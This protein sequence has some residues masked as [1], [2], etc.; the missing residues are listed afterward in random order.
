MDG[1]DVGNT[2]SWSLSWLFNSESSVFVLNAK[3]L[4]DTWIVMGIIFCVCII[5]L[6]IMHRSNSIARHALI[7]LI[8]TCDQFCTQ[9]I[10][11]FSLKHISFIAALFIFILLCNI[12]PLIPGMEE[13]TTDL[14]TTFAL[15]FIA[16][17]YIQ[18]ESI[19]KNGVTAYIQSYF[20][21]FF[22]LLPLNI[23]GKLAT[24]MSMSF[25]LF[26]NI[27]GGS[28][29]TQIYFGAINKFWLLHLLCFACGINLLITGFFTVFEGTL[30][31]FVF[32]MLTITNLGL[33]LQGEGH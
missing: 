33:A 23:I 7:M 31:A 19:K 24:V 25:R 21:P 2:H 3:T 30:Q 14:N 9:A 5:G 16:F 8:D 18:Y 6:I 12:A 15:G 20:Q 13:P 32:T 11:F 26:G 1:I 17:I 28:L 29:I 22:L 27:F 10:G 4:I